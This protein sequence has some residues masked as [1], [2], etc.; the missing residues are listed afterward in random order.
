MNEQKE[1]DWKYGR[2]NSKGTI[3]YRH[4]TNQTVEDVCNFLDE[5][6]V[7]YEKRLGATMLWIYSHK[8]KYAYFY[9]TGRWAPFATRGYPKKHYNAKGIEDFYTRFLLP[10]ITRET[11][12]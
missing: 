7:K 6:N 12:E 4:N 9:T 10:T 11:D 3:I 1:Y 5:H 2:T 8:Q